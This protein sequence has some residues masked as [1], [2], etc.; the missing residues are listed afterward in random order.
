MKTEGYC[1]A[2]VTGLSKNSSWRQFYGVYYFLGDSI[3]SL[4]EINF[5]LV[6]NLEVTFCRFLLLPTEIID[7]KWEYEAVDASSNL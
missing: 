2:I 4:T 1:L 3:F 5:L 7:D 6:I